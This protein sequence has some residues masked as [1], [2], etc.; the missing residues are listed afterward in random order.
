MKGKK[1]KKMQKNNNIFFTVYFNMEI[2]YG[3]S[4]PPLTDGL[5]QPRM[6]GHGIHLGANK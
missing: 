4:C 2:S 6:V 5:H 1:K 3:D